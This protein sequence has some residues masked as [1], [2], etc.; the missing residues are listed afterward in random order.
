MGVG[1]GGLGWPASPNSPI[2][3]RRGPSLTSVLFTI[4]IF[5]HVLVHLEALWRHSLGLPN[6]SFPS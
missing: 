6:K 5:G 3:L 2:T 4:L 1:V